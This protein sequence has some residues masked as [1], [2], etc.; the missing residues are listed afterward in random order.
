MLSTIINKQWLLIVVFSMMY[1]VGCTQQPENGQMTHSISPIVKTVSNKE[2]QDLLKN[3]QV[4]VLDVRSPQ[5]YKAGHIPGAINCDVN[6]ES[7][8]SCTST[9]DKN[10]PYIVYC[11]AGVRS[12]KA[13]EYLSEKGF[14][15]LFNLKS[16]FNNWDG[17][18][19]K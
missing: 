11:A 14:E 6:G 9:L 3:P 16:G 5:E 2:V 15:H 1:L 8:E 18:I 19:E 10:K 12:T 17:A 7:F 4:T 13:V